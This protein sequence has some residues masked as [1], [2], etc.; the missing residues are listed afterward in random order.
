MTQAQ[1]H[2]LAMQIL[3]DTSDSRQGL[4]WTIDWTQGDDGLDILTDQGQRMLDGIKQHIINS[5][6]Q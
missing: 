3:L 2:N 4:I 6:N 1:I 5:L